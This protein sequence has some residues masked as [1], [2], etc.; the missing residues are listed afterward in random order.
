MDFQC[1]VQDIIF[2]LQAPAHG[3]CTGLEDT[4]FRSSEKGS[5][6]LLPKNSPKLSMVKSGFVQWT[7]LRTFFS[8]LHKT[9]APSSDNSVM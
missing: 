8:H 4:K 3:C 7:H 1:G 6:F 2:L 9:V 5:I